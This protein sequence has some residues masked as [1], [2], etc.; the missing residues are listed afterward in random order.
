MSVNSL[1][2]FPKIILSTAKC[3]AYPFTCRSRLIR[4]YS[5]LGREIVHIKVGK[6]LQD[7]GVHKNLICS[8]SP[9][10]KAAF[11]SGFQECESGVLKL[12]TVEVEI[13]DLF[14]NWLYNQSLWGAEDEEYV[15]P[16]ERILLRLYVF[17][18]MVQCPALKNAAL[19]GAHPGWTCNHLLR[20]LGIRLGEHS[21]IKPT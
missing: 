15:N 8:V 13:F 21:R 6:S 3:F 16:D 7:Y 17:G 14:Y 4:W 12:V 9:Y 18:D 20:F 1:L 5:R 19:R 10:F 11:T 2:P